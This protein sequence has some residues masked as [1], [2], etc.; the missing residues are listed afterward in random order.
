MRIRFH[1]N[2][3]GEPHIHDHHVE[4][5]EVLDVLDNALERASGDT[6]TTIV[7]GRTRGGRVLKVIHAPS[8][9]GDGIFV[10]TA[11]DLPAKQVRALNRRLRRR[12]S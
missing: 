10:V 6:D 4:V 9:D 3:D 11:F 7:I 5:S 2:P 1:R 8:R 12:D